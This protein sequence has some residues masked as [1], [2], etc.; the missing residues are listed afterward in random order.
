MMYYESGAKYFW[1]SLFTSLIVSSIVCLVLIVFVSPYITQKKTKVDVPNV[2]GMKEDQASL[3]LKNK[4]LLLLISEER[5][6]PNYENGVILDQD[7]LPGFTIEKGSLIKVTM[8]K[9]SAPLIGEDA[10]PDV[11]GQQLMQAKERLEKSGYI[12]G[13]IEFQESE[14][15]LKD[16]VM[17]MNPAPGSK[18]MKG[19]IINIIVSTGVSEITVPNVYRKS[20]SGARIRL[21]KAG[22]KL[23]N[24][25]YTTNIE[26][27]F[28]I[29]VSQHPSSG[30]KVNSG[31]SVD[32]VVNREGTY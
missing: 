29:V 3:V 27:P 10:I 30:T 22:L 23:G 26:L 5:E 8:N 16:Q 4:D 6:D 25:R 13:R 17:S 15:Y 12:V 14:S 32:I 28:D 19:T 2:K 31:S 18:S 9:K 1:I 7:P 24:V 20:V 11:R 21:E